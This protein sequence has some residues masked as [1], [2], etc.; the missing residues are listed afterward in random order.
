MMNLNFKNRLTQ[1]RRMVVSFLLRTK[2][3][4]EYASEN[5]KQERG[6]NDQSFVVVLTFLRSLRV[7]L[8]YELIN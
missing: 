2:T 3:Y 1:I 6:E 5:E 7:N 8:K 4:H